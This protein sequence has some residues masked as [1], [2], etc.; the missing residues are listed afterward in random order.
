MDETYISGPPRAQMERPWRTHPG[1]RWSVLAGPIQG[2]GE[3]PPEGG[4]TP[5]DTL[6]LP[7]LVV[8]AQMGRQPEIPLSAIPIPDTGGVVGIRR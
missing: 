1:P 8:P 7:D 6:V 3:T 2:L 4:A 5:E